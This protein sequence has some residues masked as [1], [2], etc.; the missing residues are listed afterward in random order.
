MNSGDKFALDTY[1]RNESG[2]CPIIFLD[3]EAYYGGY[4][5]PDAIEPV[6][7]D[8]IDLLTNILDDPLKYLASHWIGGDYTDQWYPDSASIA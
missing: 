2:E 6:A 3:H 5:G 7:S 4:W 1:H 8:A